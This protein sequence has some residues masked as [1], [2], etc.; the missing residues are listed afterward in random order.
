MIY[1]NI[2]IALR[3]LIG[4]KVFSPVNIFGLA[5][6]LTTCL[7]IM[8]Y[9]F[10]EVNYDKHHLNGDRIFRI[11]SQVDGE[12]QGW[13]ALCAPLAAGVKQ[14]LPV[15]EEVTRLLKFPGL[16]KM[17]LEYEGENVVRQFYETN[18]YYVDSTYF[19]IFKYDFL[20]G[21]Q[22]NAL[23]APNSMVISEEISQRL[24]SNENPIGK[25]ITVGMPFGN[26]N[27]TV[28]GV[29][30][31][32]YKTHIPANFFLSM[33][34][35]D[36]GTWVAAQTEWTTNNI[37]HTYVRLSSVN[38]A[39][40]FQ[41]DLQQFLD[42][43]AGNDMEEAGFYR[44]LF[45]QPIKDI[46]L[47]SNLGYEIGTNGNI[48][49]LYI[50][51]SIGVFILLIACINFINLSTARS[52]KQLLEIG[53]RKVIGADRIS[54]IQQFISE[55][56]IISTLALFC[57]LLLSQLLS[58]LLNELAQKEINLFDSSQFLLAVVILAIT[59]GLFAGLYPA[60]YL[61]SF[62]PITALKGKW[63]KAA[64]TKDLRKSLVVFQFV[65]SICLIF[66]AL[67]IWQQLDYLRNYD[68]GFHKEQQII[69]PLEDPVSQQNYASLKNRLLSIPEINSVAA[70]S[71]YPGIANI[72]SMLFYPEGKTVEQAINVSLAT[73]E[74]G[75]IE[76][77]GI[78][79]LE[80]R[81][82]LPE[83]SD[84][85][86]IILNEAA[87][88]KLGYTA[89][90]AIGREVQF[91]FQ[92]NHASFQVIGVVKNFNFE[93]LHNEIKPYGFTNAFFG[94]KHSFVVARLDSK[95]YSSLL[96]RLED[97][98]GKIN[99][100]SPFVYSFLDQDFQRNYEQH[101]RTSYIVIFF[102]M[103]AVFIAC[104]GLFGLTAFS[105]SQ[106][107]REIGI[108]KV[109]GASALSITTLLSWDLIRLVVIAIVISI[110]LAWWI[111]NKWL[112]NFAYQIDIKWWMF[113]V[114]GLICIV[115]SLVTVSYQ[116]ILA[117]MAH[118]TESL[119]KE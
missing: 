38:N 80:G 21:D 12:E 79:L 42:D 58:P 95:D 49:F 85:M 69:I 14:D 70:G 44:R 48:S 115:I 98:W 28:T 68:L 35:S 22:F 11:A 66:G 116:S 31:S 93:S 32:T 8:T 94:N 72:S 56:L 76:T 105:T 107:T 103:V 87:V 86:G 61:S 5:V 81:T 102:T 117:A 67:I 62:K 99:P 23:T 106:R 55:S 37:F 65:I 113:I 92:K 97:A 109:L 20:V 16:E 2:K 73:V 77:L 30:S 26:Y 78:Q 24:F 119:R 64:T 82:F 41:N 91:D 17:K 10:E 27:Y 6:G 47:H 71:T 4:N 54:L 7:L 90:N 52:E 63:F 59:T 89:E 46:Y 50:L 9:I 29:F 118:P 1:S 111:M 45:V 104:L 51:G 75:Y 100:A 34:N 43:R 96:N 3:R 114:S 33:Q 112:Q 19:R 18:G 36:V 60:L 110:P 39:E 84:S 25:N 83:S 57:A 88:G 108:R 13:A 101:E 53:V 74:D 40:V 15:V